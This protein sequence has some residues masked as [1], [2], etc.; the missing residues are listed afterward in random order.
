MAEEFVDLYEVLEL[1]VDADRNTLRKRINELYLDAQRNLDH[2][3]FATR[4]RYQE[5]FEV[6]LPQARY[7]LL[8]DGRRDEY[9]RLVN[10]FRGTKTGAASPEAT[11]ASTSGF[12][13]A[14]PVETAIPGS[15]GPQIDAL[16]TTSV[17]P[18]TLA[19]ERE[20]LWKKWKSGLEAALTVEADDKPKARS[21]ATSAPSS[22]STQSAP[23]AP[24]TTPTPPPT[25]APTPAPKPARPKIDISFA[26]GEDNAPK[27]GEAA[28]V[29]GAEELVE[30][31]KRD[32][33]PEELERR[34][35][36]HRREI[37]KELLVNVG[38]VWG[39]IGAALVVV[40]GLAA[41]VAAVG[42]YYPRNAPPL[43]K[44]SP[45]LLWF[46]GFLLIGIATYFAS[47]ALSK[48]MR[49]KKAQELSLLSYEELL[50]QTGKS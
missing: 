13:L 23:V 5:L 33:S 40:P 9:D 10:A 2:R 21:A 38:L 26:F 46:A 6:T 43:L 4:V 19:R 42:H 8:D 14:E 24:Q 36:E 44:Y 30:Q 3:T 28:P 41:L 35:T 7:I 15:R 16:P 11:S 32:H 47:A 45:N 12:S 18:E 50:R 39:S 1:P 20:E 22:F 48:A 34:R 17:D 25:P 31:H 49:R 27:R 37:M 29:P